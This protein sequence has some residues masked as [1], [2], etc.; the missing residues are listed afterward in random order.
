MHEYVMEDALRSGDACAHGAYG[1]DQLEARR[2]RTNGST[3]HV[4]SSHHCRE[5]LLLRDYRFWF[6]VDHH[7]AKQGRQSASWR[8]WLPCGVAIDCLNLYFEPGEA[9]IKI[10][11]AHDEARP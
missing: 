4:E 3:E 1:K 2:L 10:Y 7:C 5:I 9:R 11:S 6:P 8:R